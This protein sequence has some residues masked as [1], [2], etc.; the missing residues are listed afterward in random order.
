[1]NTAL[2]TM[3]PTAADASTPAARSFGLYSRMRMARPRSAASSMTEA[4]PPRRR[5]ISSSRSVRLGTFLHLNH[6]VVLPASRR[7]QRR[8][9][10]CGWLRR[11]SGERQRQRDRDR[12]A[13]VDPA[14][15]GQ[16]AAMQRHQAL[17]DR[18]AEPGAFVPPLI[19]LAG[20]EE[21]IAKPLHIL[22]GN[23]DAVVGH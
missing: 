23:A 20:L 9:I 14:L 8:N 11:P 7:L 19:G 1:M 4:R 2:A 18:Q 12:G 15:H 16:L 13:F 6:V 5:G 21:R 22:G 10:A 3:A 17:D